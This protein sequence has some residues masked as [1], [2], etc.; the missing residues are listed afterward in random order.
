MRKLRLRPEELR[1]ES[2]PTARE[3]ARA[4]TVLGNE[5]P[6]YWVSDCYTGPEY[7]STCE[8]V[9]TCPECASPPETLNICTPPEETFPC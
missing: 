6:T 4:G 2:F 1:V 5:L 8:P 7:G 3:K 9:Y